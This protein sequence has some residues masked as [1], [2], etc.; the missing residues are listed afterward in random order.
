[1]GDLSAVKQTAGLFLLLCFN[2]RHR[3]FYCII[4]NAAEQFR[5][6]YPV[7][8]V[9]ILCNMINDAQILADLAQLRQGHPFRGAI[10][11]VTDGSVRVVQVRDVAHGSIKTCGE[12]L[13]TEIE[14]R[15]E[16]DWLR[17]G[18]VLLVAR[19]S[20]HYAALVSNPP[21]QAVA[22]PHLYVMR[23]LRPAQ[24]LPAFL[25]WQLNQGPV[26]RYLQTAAEGTLQRSVRRSALDQL[27][28]S[29]PPVE[30]QLIIL[31]LADIAAAERGLYEC[32]IQNRERELAAIAEQLLVPSSESRP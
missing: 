5:L 8:L 30:R 25:A 1:M 31:R 6:T 3:I 18:D 17:D 24:L 16:P 12:W 10:P 4:F 2:N 26:Q 32:L 19:G 28:L 11:E 22:S 20:S 14:G 21:T 27:P 13:A 23:V 29:V 15:K 9:S 7:G